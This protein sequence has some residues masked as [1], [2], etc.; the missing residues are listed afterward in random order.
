M[1]EPNIN[2]NSIDDAIQQ[3]VGFVLGLS[4]QQAWR[5]CCGQKGLPE[6]E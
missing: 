1:H 2:E 5:S 3:R 4:F 6:T